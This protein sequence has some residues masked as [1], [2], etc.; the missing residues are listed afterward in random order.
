MNYKHFTQDERN[1]ISIL[2]KKNYSQDDIAGVL[3]KHFSSVKRE[4][5]RNSTNG[6]YDPKKANAKSK[7]RRI[8]SKYQC[9][10]I[11]KH[12]KLADFIEASLKNDHWTPEEIAGRWNKQNHLDVSGE[13]ITVSPP[14]IYKYLYSAHG[15]KL[16]AYLVS[17][18]YTRKKRKE[19]GKTKKQLIPNRISIEQRP[20][21]INERIE[22][23][24]CEGDTLGRIKGDSDVVIGL[25]ERVS[26]FIMV[27]MMP[28]LKYTI[29]GFEMLLNPY[30]NIF[31]SLTLD[32]GVENIKYERLNLDTYFCH[33]YS[34][35][36][37][38]GMENLFGRLRRFIPKK[39]SLK[40]YT[41][42]QIIGFAV[43]MNNTPRKC[44]NWQTP[45][46]VFEEQ[47]A[48]KGITID[49]NIYSKVMHL[50]I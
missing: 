26:R 40:D 19:G 35:W 50:T 30:R 41:R 36:E 14:S 9:M 46:E 10:K 24:H 29:N 38:G 25:T 23:G 5:H 1:E 7:T 11:V 15:Q 8:K 20:E 27:D 17:K 45:R 12:S 6:I 13:K 4:I 22:F 2:L 3:G 42:E 48:L 18:R 34:S 43:I 37:K 44:L 21:K 28:G 31:L 39:A 16:C 47:C 49:L 32:N 33:P